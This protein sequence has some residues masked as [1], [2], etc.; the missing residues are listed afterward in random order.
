MITSELMGATMLGALWY[1]EADRPEG[2]WVHARKIITHANKLGDGHDFYNSTQ[3]PFL[4]RDGGR[5]V[6][7]R[8]RPRTW[9][10]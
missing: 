2:R 6:S 3:H 9:R 4:D 8:V 10:P 1:S 5:V 7:V